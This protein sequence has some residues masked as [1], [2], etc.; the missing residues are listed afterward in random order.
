[1]TDVM[2]LF[3][4]LKEI[5]PVQARNLMAN[6]EESL[7][8]IGRN[9]CG[10]CRLFL[11]KLVEVADEID[12]DFYFVDSTNTASDQDLAD[13]REELGVRTVPSLVVLG[14]PKRFT[15]LNIDSSIPSTDLKDLLTRS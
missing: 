2:N 8:F 10:F 7:I 4:S 13:L 14:G 11:P 15:N 1:M 3:A 6:N 5:S 9:S 12:Q